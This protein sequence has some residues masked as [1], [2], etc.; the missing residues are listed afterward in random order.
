MWL[1]YNIGIYIYGLLIF[2][3]S[4]FDEKAKKRYKGQRETFRYLK[5]RINGQRG[6]L[7]I[8]AASYGEFE[9]A[10]PI[11]ESIKSREPQRKILLT[12]F[13]PS[14][15][16]AHKEYKWADYI[17]YLPLDTLPNAIRFVKQVRPEMGVFVKYEFWPNILRACKS[18]NVPVCVISAHFRSNQA[19]F[20][21]Y[22]RPYVRLLRIFRQIFVQN[23]ESKELLSRVGVEAVTV[24]GDTRF[25]RV[26][27][28]ALKRKK[29]PIVESFAGEDRIIVAGSSWPKDE[30]ML[31]RYA[32]K[33]G[34]KLLL[35]PHEIHE[36]HLNWIEERWKQNGKDKTIVRYTEA[37][38]ENVGDKQCLLINNFGM[39]SS[40]YYY[41]YVAYVGG[42]FGVGIHNT[43][44]AAVYA[45][46]VVFGPN[47]HAFREAKELIETG[48]GFS[49][50]DYES[51][52][53][54]MDQLM[55]DNQTAGQNAGRYVT[56]NRGATDVILRELLGRD[57]EQR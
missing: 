50:G 15:Y 14:G 39:L 18:R 41:G 47:Y 17:C 45:M 57:K 35:A 34:V 24:A 8:H 28:I 42:G 12:F 38:E 13:S 46:P 6:I 49:V 36:S 54:T 56:E 31:I 29:L 32:Q 53:K 20:R 40:V 27:E 25:D 2:V 3:A 19:F 43:L 48:G 4:F 10:R 23:Q 52:E 11:I 1:L 44:E 37:T 22:G 26:A 7:W 16:E 9:Q 30:E 21:W 33:R 55:E 51:F 5:S